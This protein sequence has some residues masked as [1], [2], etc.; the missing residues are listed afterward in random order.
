MPDPET[1]FFKPDAQEPEEAQEAAIVEESDLFPSDPEN[2]SLEAAEDAEEPA[3]D[4]SE[5]ESE[6][7]AAD[8]EDDDD[9]A[10]SL[11]VEGDTVPKATFLKRLNKVIRQRDDAR[12]EALEVDLVAQELE[13]TRALL[14]SAE[15]LQGAVAKHYKDFENPAAQIAWDASFIGSFEALAKN[16]PEIQAT[17]SQ[18]LEHMK[19][20][21]VPAVTQPNAPAPESNAAAPP[22][23]ERV[24]V[25]LEK[26]ARS[27]I[28]STLDGVSVTPEWQEIIADYMLG[29]EDPED[30]SP[31]RVKDYAKH[32]IKAKGLKPEQVLVTKRGSVAGAPKPATQ[33][34]AKPGVVNRKAGDERGKDAPEKVE[35]I[36]QWEENRERFIS[37]VVNSSS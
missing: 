34:S 3:D 22:R 4:D 9:D 30:I 21:K 14:Q 18:V 35:S 17:A 19:S 37:D 12:G 28:T 13:S 6:L 27:T 36:S 31:A 10:E 33:G 2:S 15:A 20:G 1:P 32:F 25:L 7:F 29:D 23:D 8:D 11:E 16:N 24:D 26:E 5:P